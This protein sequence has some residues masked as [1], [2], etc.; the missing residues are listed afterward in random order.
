MTGAPVSGAALADFAVRAFTSLR[1]PEADARAVAEL[2]VE[3]DLLGYDTHGLFRLRQ[4][5]N[6]LRDGGCN[7]A[8][9]PHVL[10]ET[11]ATALIDGDNGLGQL[12]MAQACD[13][14]ITKA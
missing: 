11:V 13:M 6:R 12:A 14:A 1:V 4:Y 3:A 7:P 8:A 2:M 5:V 9:T 10:R